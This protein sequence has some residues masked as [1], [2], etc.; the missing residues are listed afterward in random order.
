MQ[1]VNSISKLQS[2][3]D[4]NNGHLGLVPTMGAL[5]AGHRSLFEKAR[6][7]NDFLAVSLFVNPSQF[8]ANEDF[9]QY[10]RDL[11]ND[12]SILN[13]ENVDLVFIP[14]VKEIY[15]A[16]FSTIVIV[17][18]LTDIYEGFHRQGHF[19]GVTTVVAKLFAI[20]KPDRAYFGAKD[21]QQCAVIKRLNC[22]LNLGVEIVICSTI[23]EESGLALSSR[24]TYL[25]P[26]QT[27]AAS[28]I[29]KGLFEALELFKSGERN[30]DILCVTVRNI[31]ESNKLSNIDYLEMVNCDTFEQQTTVG[32]KSIIIIAVRIGN[33]RLI[34]NIELK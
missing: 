11:D 31:I 18:G 14:D 1:V 22:D 2:E 15:P 34:D 33:I 17:E 28:L 3:L 7:D 10:P 26:S 5:H 9:D 4:K 32:N 13:S 8:G 6:K 27:K 29:S 30:A 23:R 24:N 12:L 25:N 21:A 20:F 16:G 19:I